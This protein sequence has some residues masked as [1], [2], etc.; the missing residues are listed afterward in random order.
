MK[1]YYKINCDGE[2]ELIFNQ[3]K[4]RKSVN[5]I[6]LL[7]YCYNVDFPFVLKKSINLDEF[8]KIIDDA[9]LM[10]LTDREE[11][12]LRLRFGIDNNKEMTLEQLGE[13]FGL[14]KERIR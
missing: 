12:I 11:K 4:E 5:C 7:N 1:Y 6:K 10:T 13:V 3:S 2:I 9:F 14:T 8:D